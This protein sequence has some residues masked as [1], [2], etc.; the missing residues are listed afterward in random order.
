MTYFFSKVRKEKVTQV[1]KIYA[2]VLLIHEKK[3]F[4]L[5]KR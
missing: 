2:Y 1:M 3:C 4:S 5:Y